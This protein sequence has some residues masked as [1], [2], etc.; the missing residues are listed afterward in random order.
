[1][2]ATDTSSIQRLI[3][4]ARR[5]IRRQWALEGATTALILASALALA[6]VFAMR[7]DM[8]SMTAGVGALFGC[9][10]L[11][12]LGAV[13]GAA[14][15]LDDELVARRIDRA[16]GLSDR[17][18]TAIAFKRTLGGEQPAAPDAAAETEDLMVAAIKDGVRAVPRADIVA[19]APY[20]MPRDLRA[21]ALFTV[22]S[23][24]AAGLIIRRPDHTPKLFK[25]SPDHARPGEIAIIEGE[26]L[27]EGLAV[28]EA[29]DAGKFVPA[30]GG[31][32]LGAPPAY[33]SGAAQG[34]WAGSGARAMTVL[35]WNRS[36][37]TIRVPDDAPIGD[38]VLYV[39]IGEDRYGPVEFTVVDLKDTRYHKEDSVLLDPDERAYVERI[40]EQLRIVAKRDNVPE[41][42]DFADK[43]EKMLKE[44]EEGKITKEQLL[45][46]LKKAEEALAAHAEPNQ[47]EIDKQMNEMGKELAK[48][49][50]TKALGEALQKKDLQK[51][52]E[53]L[54]KLANRL[55]PEEMKQEIEKLEKQLENK[56]L[57]DKEKREIQ[58]K[59]DELKQQ[60]EQMKKE[61]EALEKA[62]KDLKEQIKDLEKQLQ[63][64]NLTEKQKQELQKK[65]DELKQQLEQAQQKKDE[66]QKKQNELDDQKQ[67]L[68]KQLENKQ[69][70]EQEKQELQ[71]KLDDLKQQKPMTEQEKQQ[72]QKQLEKVSQQ[73]QK[74]Q[75][76]QQQKTEQQQQKLQDEIKRLQKKQQ[77]AKTEKEKLD[78]ERQL[79]KKKDELQKLDKD[80][81]DKD[82]SAQRQ[83][84]KRL[85]RDMEKAAENLEKGQKQDQNKDERDEE[86]KE[87]DKQASR[88]LK[89]AA[90][91]TGRVDRDQRKQ[92]AQKKMSS[93]MDDLREAMRRAKQKGNKGPQD[94]FG[95]NGKNKDFAQ[96]ARGQKGS[97]QAW[98]PG[99]GQPGGQGKGQGQGQQP[100]QGGGQ[101][102]DSWGTEHDDNLTGDAT[103]K[104]GKT[105]DD[106]LQGTQGG[107]GTSRRE[108]ILS[109]AQKGFSS[110]SYQKVYA[111][112]EKIVEE[113]MR[114]EK[115]PSSYKYY[116]KRYFAKIHPSTGD[117]ETSPQDAP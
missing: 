78:A 86:Q 25:A 117:V 27:L 14:R 116:V 99:Q 68:Q 71:K 74:Q 40:L 49:P 104:T 45:D 110:T 113:V 53:E 32:W 101:G 44:A 3:S 43:I 63:D 46:A 19:A 80:Q 28:A 75:Q 35:D 93:Q 98:K 8:V 77:E 15:K 31:V 29:R 66:Q 23:A 59:L 91:E 82:D 88:N 50:T 96:R 84:L 112:Y 73:M 97:G 30:D 76:D 24:L 57:S 67:E 115:M 79:Q 37:I 103:G 13:I 106:D 48:D 94:P 111:D 60:L 114:N 18:S 39:Q 95:K 22:I 17:L 42:A 102:G 9:A 41:L 5:R 65:L 69:L 85:Q 81:Q 16:S 20:A 33:V 107:K 83:A 36:G 70:S 105:K 100:G 52:R 55:D 6:V 64:K 1:M 26:N 34:G 54:E 51:A 109:A 61:Q 12:L 87:R 62:E 72:L 11:V 2:Q 4:R 92:A 38:N 7:T 108:T 21:A 47:A 56:Q 10:G 89:D 90:R 58:K